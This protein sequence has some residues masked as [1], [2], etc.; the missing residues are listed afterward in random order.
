LAHSALETILKYVQVYD[1]V[2]SDDLVDMALV[3]AVA[4]YKAEAEARGFDLSQIGDSVF[5][6]QRQASLAEGLVRAWMRVRLPTLLQEFK[7]VS[8]EEEWEVPLDEAGEIVLMTR[9]DCLLERRS[10]GELWPVEFKTTGWM[11]DDWLESWRYSTQTL[12]QVWAVE[13]HTRKPCG[14]VLVEALYKGVKRSDEVKGITYYSPLIRGYIKRGVPPFDEDELSWDSSVGR[15]KGWEPVDVW[16]WGKVKEWVALLPDEVVATQIFSREVFR[17]GKEMETWERQTIVEQRR[18]R[19]A[20][21]VMAHPVPDVEQDVLDETFPARLSQDC[22]SNK[23]RMRCPM[24][25]VCYNGLDPADDE[26]FVPR[27]AHHPQEFAAS[28]E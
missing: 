18:I 9:L 25:Q 1:E 24:L 12:Q 6:M 28:D 20:V 16:Q 26:G 22:F 10:D 17:S 4:T 7:V 15:K 13:K 21:A 3:Q 5:E 8:C 2:P 23:Y 19:D 27:V 14:G 11:S